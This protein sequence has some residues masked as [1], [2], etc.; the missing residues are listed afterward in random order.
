MF[1][2]PADVRHPIFRAFGAEA[3]SLGLVQFRTVARV[4]GRS[5]QAIA[6]FTSGEPA[7]LDCA[8]GSGRTMVI[9]SDLNNRWNDFPV[10]ASFVPFLDQAVRYLSSH[11][12]R[13]SEFLVGDVPPG[14]KPIPG[15]TTI[16]SG[17]GARR[18]IVNVDPRESAGGRMSPADFQSAITRLKDD[19]VKTERAD[20]TGQESRQHLWQF[21]LGAMMLALAAEGIVAARS[22]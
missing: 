20:A 2:A 16:D 1:L 13:A 21:L 10:R 7:V 12:R 4:A 19:S 17:A 9:A 8:A 3:A 18:V 15:V 14:V 5:C 22:A 11:G 6:R